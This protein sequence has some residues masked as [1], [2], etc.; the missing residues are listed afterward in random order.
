LVTTRA[1]TRRCAECFGRDLK[2]NL[3]TNAK[4]QPATT[5]RTLKDV[6]EKRRKLLELYYAAAITPE[7]LKI[8]EERL[9]A[10]VAAASRDGGPSLEKTVARNEPTAKFDQVIEIIRNLNIDEI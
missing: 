10:A 4:K 5:A 7:G 6:G 2:S 9:L 1:S 3:P 8:E